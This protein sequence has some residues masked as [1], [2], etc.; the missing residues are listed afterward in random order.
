MVQTLCEWRNI[1]LEAEVVHSS[2]LIGKEISTVINL[3][4]FPLDV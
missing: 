4:F 2:A 3:L 1:L